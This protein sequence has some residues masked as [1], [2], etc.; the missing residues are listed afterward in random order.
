MKTVAGSL[1]PVV[2]LALLAVGPAGCGNKTEVRRPES[3]ALAVFTGPE[4]FR[5]TVGSL[6]SVGGYQPTLVS[7][8]GIVVGLNNTGSADVPPALRPWLMNEMGRLGIGRGEFADIS[9]QQLLNSPRTA[10][11]VVEGVI[12]AGAAQG[13]RFDV[14]VA[15]LSADSQTTSLEGGRLYTT[16]LKRFGANLSVPSTRTLATANGHL[17]LNPFVIT[18]P[19]APQDRPDDPRLARIMAGGV[20]TASRS[21]GLSLNAPSY[22]RSRE[23]ADRINGRYP[24]APADKFPM[25]I[26]KSDQAIEINVLKRYRDEPTRMFEVISHLY[27]NPTTQFNR[28]KAAELAKALQDPANAGYARRI[29]LAW[30]AMGKTI[31]PILRPQYESESALVRSTALTAGARLDDIRAVDPLIE[32]ATLGDEADREAATEALG[33]MLTRRP[34][35]LRLAGALRSMLDNDNLLV[36]LA[37]FEALYKVGDPVIRSR[38]FEDKL[39]LVMVACEKPLIYVTRSGRPRIVLFDEML[40]IDKPAVYIDAGKELMVRADADEEFVN[41]YYREDGQTKGRTHKIA[42]AVANLIYLLAHQPS[43]KNYTPGFNFEYGPIV[44]ILHSMNKAGH[45]DAPIVMQPT[46]LIEQIARQKLDRDVETRP[47]G[48]DGP[49]VDGPRPVTDTETPGAQAESDG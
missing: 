39:E 47:E 14:A 20:V 38:V 43:D 4:L 7:G 23:I 42:P 34:D 33:Y 10:V 21:V 9:P 12:P 46:D 40:P 36:R 48:D 2:A 13:T 41:V 8:Y 22:R 26:A 29:G 44:R 6:T 28:E 1:L 24:A 32:A 49:A 19:E 31:L 37:A 45:I 27:L 18:D 3:P 17:F 16:E 11:V 5:G 30:E 35:H 25:A 15:A